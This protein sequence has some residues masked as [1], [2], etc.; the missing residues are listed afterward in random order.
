MD[1]LLAILPALFWGSIVLFN[2]KLGGGPYSQILGTT[3]GAL[4]FSIGVYIFIKPV[5]TPVMIIVGIISGLFWALGQANQL[6]S[7]DLIGVSK[8][9]PISTGMQL[10]STTLFG[11]IVFHEWSTTTSVVLGVLALLCIIIGIVL[12]SL[13]SKEEKNDEQK[14]NFKKGIVMLLISTLGYLVYV[15]I[16]RL[17]GIDGWSAL[18]P[19]AIGMVL[20]GILLTF[21]HQPFNKYAIHNIIPGLIWAA[22]N[23]FLFISQPRVGVATSFSLSQ[24]GIVIS[25]L[26]GIFILGE[27]KTKRQFIAI[28]IGI[29]FIIAAGIMLGIAK[30]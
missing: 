23:M 18:L 8:T 16:I 7:I 10:V 6:K 25:T 30:G 27:K 2:V 20:G 13:Q 29:I 17:F 28:V 3:L 14:G 1:I 24:M 9:M 12:T 21:K 11:V 19:Q 26:G 4:V 15:V 22:G 5:L